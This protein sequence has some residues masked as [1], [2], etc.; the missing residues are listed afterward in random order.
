M[1]SARKDSMPPP[2][3]GGHAAT[4]DEIK[5]L[6]GRIALKWL[7]Q[8]RVAAGKVQGDGIISC[9]VGH[10]GELHS[11]RIIVLKGFDRHRQRLTRRGSDTSDEENDGNI[12][13]VRLMCEIVSVSQSQ[14]LR[15][16]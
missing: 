1:A 15:T 14:I 2:S 13:P 4:I 10:S 6:R 8:S 16:M 7:V 5:R 12:H 9:G 11:D 3:S